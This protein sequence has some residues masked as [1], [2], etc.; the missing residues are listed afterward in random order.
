MSLSSQI[1][2]LT[3]KCKVV[4]PSYVCCCETSINYIYIRSYMMLYVPYAPVI[5]V[6]HQL[7]EAPPCYGL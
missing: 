4:P 1:S 5:G 6:G 3:Q 2:Q 7:N